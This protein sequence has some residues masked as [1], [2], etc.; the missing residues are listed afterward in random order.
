MRRLSARRKRF[1]R[2]CEALIE[3]SGFNYE[4]WAMKQA[5]LYT[6]ESNVNG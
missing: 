5:A 1:E 6:T 2:A 3:V 4:S